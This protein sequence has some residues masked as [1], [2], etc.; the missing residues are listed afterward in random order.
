MISSSPVDGELM[1][2]SV[3]INRWLLKPIGI[4][5]L[6]LCSGTAEKISIIM[7]ELI[8]IFL[9]GYLLVP[10]TLCAI[11]EKNGDLDA[12]IKMI[13][14]LSFCVMA[15]VKYCILLSRGEQI[16]ECIRKIWSDWGRCVSP[17]DNQNREIMIE[18]ARFGRFLAVF[19][20]GFMY[21]GGFFYTTVMPLCSKRTEIIGNETVRSL[22]FPI[23]R[24]II[25]PRTSPSF[26]IAQLMQCL[27][28][29]VI[30]SVTVGACS[31]AAVFVMHACG[32]FKILSVRLNQLVNSATASTNRKSAEDYLGDIV[33]HHLRILGFISKVE[34]L[35]N[36]I[37]F[38]E[39][40]GC[41]LNICFLG[42]FVLTEWEQS[43]TVGAMTYCILLISFTFNI[44]ILCYIGEILSEEC[45]KL[46]LTAYMIKWYRL[47][48]RKA[49]GL[50]LM[51]AMSNS[52][53]KLTAGKIVNLSLGSFCSVLKSSLAYLSLLRT[54]TT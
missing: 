28:G 37:C 10:C 40:V 52:S 39:F 14:P 30:Y 36:E 41:T 12:K 22:A 1:L 21:S 44:F 54:L 7:L 53:T 47:P 48:G 25:D 49:L 11:L 50:V 46:G 26:E 35:L 43:D 17:G 20:A 45:I 38:V 6:A 34:G 16:S 29:F 2:Y 42:Y 31:L 13:G 19:C 51:L 23:Y 27:A 32:Q 15:A 24:G 8:S 9:I 18:S 33:Q 5:P 3:Q 4:W